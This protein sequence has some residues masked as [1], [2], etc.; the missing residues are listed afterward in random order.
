MQ[1]DPEI[2]KL[3]DLRSF[4]RLVYL[5]EAKEQAEQP[6]TSFTHNHASLKFNSGF[7]DKYPAAGTRSAVELPA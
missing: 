7:V 5:A 4:S 3:S 1:N 2:L 6:E